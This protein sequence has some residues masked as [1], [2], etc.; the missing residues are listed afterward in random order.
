MAEFQEITVRL[1]QLLL[2]PN[3]YRFQDSK[4]FVQAQQNRLHEGNVQDRA[5]HRIQ[6]DGLKQLKDSIMKNGF[7]TFEKLVVKKYLHKD[8]TFIVVEGN[9]RLA[10]MRWI[11][12]DHQSGVNVSPSVL[13]V[14]NSLPV[15]LLE[16]DVDPVYVHAL[17][18]VR[19]VSGIKQWV[20]YQR[21]KLVATMRDDHNLEAG[22][23]AERLGLST[24][25][26]NRRYRA[27]KALEQMK[28]DEA[29][30]DD[31]T[32]E[33]YPLFHEAVSLPP[34][35][36]WLGWEDKDCSFEDRETLEQFYKLITPDDSE[37]ATSRDPKIR[38]YS[39]VRELR[40]ILSNTDAKAVLLDP[41]RSFVDALSIAKSEELSKAWV[42]KVGSAIS[43]LNKIGA[44]EL[45]RLGN[46]EIEQLTTLRNLVDELLEDRKK[47]TK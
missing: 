44:L 37:E 12:K 40:S 46:Q 26:V 36:D 20:G 22:E 35:R 34:V 3:N 33:M 38:T 45:K 7:L 25:E 16:D 30:G 42:S 11:K 4:D 24:H 10:S 28:R 43:A 27:F 39:E 41:S 14:M 17:L 29:V 19:H 47:L 21:A 8:D 5:F 18:G 1:D 23:V 32:P 2:D 6:E 9:R 15:V 31:A 13:N